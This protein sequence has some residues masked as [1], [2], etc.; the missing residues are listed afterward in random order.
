M[1]I[2][3]CGVL[4]IYKG[5]KSVKQALEE[6]HELSATHFHPDVVKAAQ[7]ALADIEIDK[8]ITQK[9]KS[10]MEKE[11]FSYFYRDQLTN[12][13][14][15]HYLEY[16]LGQRKNKE[17]TFNCA[18][19]IYLSNFSQ[20]NKKFGWSKGDE[21]IVRLSEEL[22]HTLGD[23]AIFRIHGDDFIVL[24]NQY[25]DLNIQTAIDILKGTDITLKMKYFDL[26]NIYPNTK[27]LK[28]IMQI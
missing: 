22:M 19:G 14:N 3:F 26:N 16:I 15:Q 18:Y 7:I 10:S 17:I 1:K 20:Y 28:D 11:R 6:L 21:I 5:R 4:S 23:G 12:L 25:H 27:E 24:Y 9:P 2:E 13:Y 8:S